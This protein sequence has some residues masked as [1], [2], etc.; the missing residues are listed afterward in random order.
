MANVNISSP[1]EDATLTELNEKLKLLVENFQ[2]KHNYA[3]KY[4]DIKQDSNWLSLYD[5]KRAYEL[6]LATPV[7]GCCKVYIPRRRRYCF[8]RAADNCDNMCTNHYEISISKCST[9]ID[10]QSTAPVASNPSQQTRSIDSNSKWILKSNIG[11]R[12][13]KMTN[14]LARQF[15]TRPPHDRAPP[16]DQV[17]EDPSLPVLLDIGVVLRSISTSLRWSFFFLTSL[18]GCA[19]GRFLHKLA[20]SEPFRSA[21]GPHNF[22]GLEVFE[23]LVLAANLAA[24]RLPHRNLHYLHG[25]AN[26]CDFV[27]LFQYTPADDL[28]GNDSEPP[29]SSSSSSQQKRP[30]RS[31]TVSRVCVQFPDPWRGAKAVR[32]VLTPALV[33]VIADLLSPGGEL[34]LSSD[35]PE[36]AW[37]MRNKVLAS[38]LFRLHELHR[39]CHASDTPWGAVGGAACDSQYREGEHG[40][41][42]RG[43][44]LSGRGLVADEHPGVKVNE[45]GKEE[46]VE[47]EEE[48]EK[49]EEEEETE[50]GS[51]VNISLKDEKEEEGNLKW[52]RTRPY[53]VATEREL[54]CEVKR[55]APIFRMLLTKR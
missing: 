20:T 18:V 31:L 3:P 17:F 44:E 4:D 42:M 38:S 45:E 22:V 8:L 13:K 32:R 14:P 48:E 40:E 6:S 7:E 23:P 51:P 28:V 25:S 9:A 54:V 33:R 12:M 11:R 50:E 1:T 30:L 47:G 21:F 26:V 39:S 16:W 34:Y 19:K 41:A 52:L 15:V 49:E 43:V 29:S 27:K 2:Q 5:Q 10:H 53:F 37:Y 36:L 46:E 24:E 35:V 55:N